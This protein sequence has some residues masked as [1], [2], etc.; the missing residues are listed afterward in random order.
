MASLTAHKTSRP[1]GVCRVR[2]G[3]AR[4]ARACAPLAG[5][6]R[7][8]LA[9]SLGILR[10]RC[11]RRTWRSCDES[12][13]H[14]TVATKRACWPIFIPR[15]NGSTPRDAVEPGI[16]SGHEEFAGA[17]RAVWDTFED[18]HVE[19]H[20]TVDVGDQVVVVAKLCGRGRGSG[21]DFEVWL[22]YVFTF[23]DGKEARFE[24][25]NS[26]TQAFEAAGL[27]E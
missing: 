16:R 1:D 4:A 25:F 13:M 27:R 19:V 15:S 10:G 22:S 9:S 11:R 14:S 24:W 3:S 7:C 17:I 26:P 21:A 18:A 8:G 5:R 12:S 6:A 20:E 2:L 23:R